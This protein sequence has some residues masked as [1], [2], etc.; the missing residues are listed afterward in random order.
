MVTL[1]D[2]I[3]RCDRIM[4]HNSSDHEILQLFYNRIETLESD[5]RAV[6]AY[7]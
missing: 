5:H 3:F 2:T 1:L 6:V 7:Y 4:A